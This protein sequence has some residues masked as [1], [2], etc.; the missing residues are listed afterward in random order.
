[1]SVEAIAWALNLAPIPVD[2]NGKPN[3]SCAFVLVALANHAD[4]DG[5]ATFPSVDTIIRYTRLSERTVRTSIDRLADARTIRPCPPEIVAAKITR[6]DRRPQ[7][8]DLDLTLVRDDL[9]DEDITKLERQFPGIRARIDSMKAI[10]QTD[11]CAT[12]D[13]VQPL[14]P[15]SSG[16][17]DNSFGEVQQLHLVKGTG[18]NQ[19]T[20]GVQLTQP[21]GA[22]VAPEPSIEPP[23]NPPAAYTRVRAREPKP[24]ENP[25]AGGG[26]PI[27][28]EFFGKLGPAWRLSPA[29]RDRLTSAV[30]TA[31]GVG[32][33]PDSLAA[34]VGANTDGIAHPAGVLAHRLSPAEL[35]VPPTARAN[36]AASSR[37]PWCGRCDERTRFTLDEHGYPSSARC[38]T[39]GSA[40]NDTSAATTDHRPF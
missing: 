23:R 36:S 9:T 17:V 22:A 35:P 30:S 16:P 34:Y 5:T 7:G 26:N 15:A 39:C 37:K 21:R 27:V 3:S 6:A 8:W 10:A 14:H 40:R 11:V 18:C 1:M 33:T 31:I 2:K 13:G 4:P 38:P 28:D 32:W 12:A 25:A 29:Q 20:N 24:V 19:R